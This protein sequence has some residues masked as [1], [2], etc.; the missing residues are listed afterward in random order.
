MRKIYNVFL[1]LFCLL[2]GWQEVEAQ[3]I[4]RSTLSSSGRTLFNST[5]ILSFTFG[6][7]PGC[8]TLK[9][10][11][12]IITPGFQQTGSGEAPCFSIGLDVEEVIDG[13]NVSYN[14][15]YTGD[16]DPASVE[17]TWNFGSN[18][19]PQIS[20]DANPT[21]VR[22]S[23]S[24]TVEVSLRIVGSDCEQGATASVPVLSIPDDCGFYIE[25]VLS[26]NGDN[27]NDLWTIIGLEQFPNNEVSVFNRWGQEV[28]NKSGYLNDWDGTNNSGE[29]LPVGAYYY[30][31]KLNDTDS[32]VFSGSVTIVR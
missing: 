19:V 26:P 16:A 5:G 15:V 25:D 12:G 8:G 20:N 23:D 10:D 2:F 31:L 24:V 11:S 17:F 7:C 29:P 9:S 30:I 6:Q 13:C 4:T 18:A 1:L 22:F 21:G 14:F 32:Q 3:S 27:Q 28:W